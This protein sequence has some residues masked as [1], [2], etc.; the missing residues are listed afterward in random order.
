MYLPN[1][2]NNLLLPKTMWNRYVNLLRSL[3]KTMEQQYLL[4]TK[5]Q[6]KLSM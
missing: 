6:I 2:I 5:Y 3:S 4:C 1:N